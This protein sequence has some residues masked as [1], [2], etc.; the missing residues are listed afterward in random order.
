MPAAILDFGNAVVDKVGA[1]NPL[2][3]E[4]RVVPRE[5]ERDVLSAPLSEMTQSF[6]SVP[7]IQSASTKK[8][9]RHSKSV[10]MQEETM[11][12]VN[13]LNLINLRILP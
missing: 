7:S 11:E 2:L 4:S 8:K 10:S 1:Q 9:V 6:D 5:P 3:A 13:F 12:F